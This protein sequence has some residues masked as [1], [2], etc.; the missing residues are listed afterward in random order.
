MS[1]SFVVVAEE[2]PYNV[3]TGRHGVVRL[4][5]DAVD[6]DVH[7]VNMSSSR[8]NN[9]YGSSSSETKRRKG[10]DGGVIGVVR[11][12][13]L[14]TWFSSF[15]NWLRWPYT[16]MRQDNEML[17]GRLDS[18]EKLMNQMAEKLELLDY[19]N[20]AAGRGDRSENDNGEEGSDS[21][22]EEDEGNSDDEEDVESLSAEQLE[23]KGRAL[24]AYQEMIAKN[25][26]EWKY[27]AEDLFLADIN[28]FD[29]EEI[30][31]LS[32]SIKACTIKM[33]RGDY[34]CQL[35]EELEENDDVDELDFYGVLLEPHERVHTYERWVP[36]SSELKRH[37]EEFADALNTFDLTLGIL[38]EDVESTF[39][40]SHIQLS[41]I[42]FCVDN[43]SIERQ[44]VQALQIQK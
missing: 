30:I 10:N 19:P 36:Y 25:R 2:N 26:D 14:S 22:D 23:E 13:F 28:H 12:G 9:H 16:K 42:P 29:A 6:Y 40:I 27:T 44:T 17:V 5:F 1:C 8:N 32:R 15:F 35:N 21:S 20:A 3:Y 38:D 4:G 43:K 34:H 24:V 11:G 39:Q 33:R 31:M 37:W 18:I 7:G 41:V